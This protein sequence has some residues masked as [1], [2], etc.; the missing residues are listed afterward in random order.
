MEVYLVSFSKMKRKGTAFMKKIVIPVTLVSLLLITIGICSKPFLGDEIYHFRF[1]KDA[2]NSNSRPVFDSQYGTME[3]PTILYTAPP[4]WSLSL[5]GLWKITGGISTIVA[6]F[7]QVFFYVII[8][9]STYF[10]AKELYSEKAA[11]ISALLVATVPMMVSFSIL[12][13]TDIP[14]TALCLAG[15]L[16]TIKKKYLLAGIFWSLAILTKNNAAFF[17]PAVILFLIYMKDCKCLV[18][19]KNLFYMFLPICI[20]SLME[21][22]WRL[23]AFLNSPIGIIQ[24]IS[25]KSISPEGVSGSGIIEYTNRGISL[26]GKAVSSFFSDRLI[27]NITF[28]T[29]KPI[30]H[31]NSYSLDIRDLSMYLGVVLLVLSICYLVRKK[32]EKKD[33]SI[34]I[35]VMC[36][37][38]STFFV[39]GFNTDIRYFMPMVPLVCILASK[40]LVDCKAIWVKRMVVLVCICQLSAALAYVYQKREISV[41]IKE[42][43]DFI[44]NNTPTDSLVVYPEA[45]LQEYAQRKVMWT[46]SKRSA[47][48]RNLFWSDDINKIKSVICLNEINY[49]II[50]KN[51]SYDDGHV[52][53]LG[54]YPISFV[55]KLP[56][57]EF[58]KLAFDN[59]EIAVWEV[60][61]ELL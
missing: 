37:A 54:G 14:V 5:A 10:L 59:D 39:I 48:L 1:A 42:G 58:L 16:F 55:K 7:Y 19:L 20:L 2:Y 53:H 23:N 15:I 8:I 41:S 9:V 26:L 32:Y 38:I 21:F 46:N 43:F 40:S 6:Q 49:I 61:A 11:M 25:P 13:Y 27:P 24:G 52:R 30:E 18:K 3:M 44:K 51:R 35:F 45:N 36:Y 17:L 4:F 28:F 12:L 60:E 29:K 57:Y 50:K 22:K 34:G 31:L 33:M 47:S 56:D